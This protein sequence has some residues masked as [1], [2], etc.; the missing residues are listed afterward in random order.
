MSQPPNEYRMYPIDLN[1][2][3]WKASEFKGECRIV[4]H[5]ERQAREFASE[6]FPRA[7][8]GDESKDTLF[9][10]WEMPKVTGIEL[11]RQLEPG[12]SIELGVITTNESD[13]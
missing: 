6:K 4:A 5:S 9:S 7:V 2:Q 13:D 3:N 10:P 11:V 8:S 12:D 1:S